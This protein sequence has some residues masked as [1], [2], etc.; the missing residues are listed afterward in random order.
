MKAS[1]EAYPDNIGH[2]DSPGCFRCHTDSFVSDDGET[3]FTDCTRCHLILA[4]GDTIDQVNVNIREGLAFVHPEDYD[5]IEEYTICT[6]CHD[7]GAGIY[8][9]E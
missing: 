8:D 4:Q 7:G 1:W 2:R 6:D 5:T 3:I 9:D